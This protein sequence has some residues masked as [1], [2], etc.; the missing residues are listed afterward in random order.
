M[1][2]YNQDNR[3]LAH[4]RFLSHARENEIVRCRSRFRG[5][6][7]DE[8]WTDGQNNPAVDESDLIGLIII[9]PCCDCTNQSNCVY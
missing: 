1:K 7:K 2:I 5:S 9:C 4:D 8:V 6:E 3:I